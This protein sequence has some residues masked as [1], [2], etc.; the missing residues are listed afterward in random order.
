MFILNII[1]GIFSL[2][3]SIYSIFNNWEPYKRGIWELYEPY[4]YT[5]IGHLL[6]LLKK[7]NIVHSNG[8]GQTYYRGNSYGYYG[9]LDERVPSPCWFHSLCRWVV[10]TRELLP[11]PEKLYFFFSKQG[12]RAF[13]QGLLKMCKGGNIHQDL[14][15]W[16]A[17]LA[18]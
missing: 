9:V 6:I 11:L 8:G 7:S 18:P 3:N 17:N 10:R 1:K 4:Y 13:C 2:I 12:N 16:A 5:R 15:L 14:L